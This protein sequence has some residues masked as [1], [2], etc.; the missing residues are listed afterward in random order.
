MA[1]VSLSLS[2]FSL[3]GWKFPSLFG[4]MIAFLLIDLGIGFS[5][6]DRDLVILIWVCKISLC[7]MQIIRLFQRQ[8]QEKLIKYERSGSCSNMRE[9]TIL[10]LLEWKLDRSDKDCTIWLRRKLTLK[11]EDQ[12]YGSC[13][14]QDYRGWIVGGKRGIQFPAWSAR[15]F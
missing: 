12:Q 7:K 9:T 2:N 14:P 6:S 15:E 11:P 1:V 4:F 8:I 10:L 3:Y 13:L 5:S